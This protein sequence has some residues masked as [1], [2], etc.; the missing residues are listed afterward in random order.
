[1]VESNKGR[2]EQKKT[3][4]EKRKE[5]KATTLKILAFRSGNECAFE[6]CG[7]KLASIYDS[8]TKGEA[9]HICAASSGGPRYDPNMTNEE[10]NSIDNLMYLCPNHHKEI[11]KVNPRGYRAEVLRAMKENHEKRVQEHHFSRV[12]FEELEEVTKYIVG[13][14][15]SDNP[16]NFDKINIQEKINKNLLSSENASMIKSALQQSKKVEYFLNQKAEKDDIDFP[17]KLRAGFGVEY[18]QLYRK[19]KRGHDLFEGMCDFTRRVFIGMS[20]QYAAIAVLAY[21]FETCDLFEK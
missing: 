2:S 21:F 16:Y 14:S 1:M 10:R 18:Y 6:G 4:V 12:N 3:S 5:A 13:C 15:A 7:E 9:A 17:N 8:G 19:G 11:D 20:M